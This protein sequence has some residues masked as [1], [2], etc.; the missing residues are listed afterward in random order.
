M[1]SRRRTRLASG[2]STTRS[3]SR[4]PPPREPRPGAPAAPG[5]APH[6]TR[7]RSSARPDRAGSRAA[8]ASARPHREPARRR[9]RWATGCADPR[10]PDARPRCGS[11]CD[12][13]PAPVA[14]P[15]HRPRTRTRDPA[16][17]GVS[18]A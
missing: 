10:P 3:G 7:A 17:P 4:R 8:R 15:P 5:R 12:P 1:R 13:P 18:R 9:H 11:R 16:H 2:R 14:P 6:P